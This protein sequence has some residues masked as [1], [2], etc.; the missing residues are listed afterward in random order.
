MEPI[1]ESNVFSFRKEGEIKILTRD[2]KAQ[3]CPFKPTFLIPGQIQ[4][5]MIMHRE[6]CADWCPHFRDMLVNG[7]P[8]HACAKISFI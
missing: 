4:G 5:Q 2:G 7:E 8:A 3:F 1:K 6:P